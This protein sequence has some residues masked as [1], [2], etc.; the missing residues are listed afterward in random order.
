MQRSSC[1]HPLNLVR[2][3]A[4]RAARFRKSLSG[5]LC[6]PAV[7]RRSYA[8]SLMRFVLKLAFA[9]AFQ[10]N[11]FVFHFAALRWLFGAVFPAVWLL[12]FVCLTPAVRRW[13]RTAGMEAWP[14]SRTRPPFSKKPRDP[15][16]RVPAVCREHPERE[17]ISVPLAKRAGLHRGALYGLSAVK[18]HRRQRRFVDSAAFVGLVRRA[19]HYTADG[20]V[21]F[22]RSR[23]PVS[24]T[25]LTLPTSDLV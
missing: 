23:S 18:R 20:L 13:S 14:P 4:D 17:P 8:Q 6:A 19:T 2:F 25:H 12:S 5:V 15:T 11:V 7:D 24:Y 21:L 22:N 16:S 3:A 1:R 10:K 9:S